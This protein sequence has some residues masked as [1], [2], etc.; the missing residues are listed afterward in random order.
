MSEQE[1]LK[2]IYQDV[3]DGQAPAVVEGVGAAI[4]A[5]IDVNDI[6]NQALVLAYCL[7]LM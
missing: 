4:A 6:L 5:G 1:T 2:T 3:I 7:W